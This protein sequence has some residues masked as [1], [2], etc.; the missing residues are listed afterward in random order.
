MAIFLSCARETCRRRVQILDASS[1]TVISR[2]MGAKEGGGEMKVPARIP[3]RR[4]RRRCSKLRGSSKV[5]RAGPV[6]LPA[7]GRARHTLVSTETQLATPAP[8]R[9]RW[10]GPRGGMG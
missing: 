1:R 10:R 8:T 2:S 9:L 7:P 3:A 6:L 5:M 4:W